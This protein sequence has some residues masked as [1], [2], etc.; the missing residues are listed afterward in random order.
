MTDTNR[1]KQSHNDLEITHSYTLHN[2]GPSDAKRTE[3]QL[4]WPMLPLTDSTD[5]QSLLYGNELPTITRISQ[6]KSNQDRCFIY[7]PVKTK[8]QRF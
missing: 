6:P 1:H 8:T 4:M 3:I 2:K 5:Q 7:Q